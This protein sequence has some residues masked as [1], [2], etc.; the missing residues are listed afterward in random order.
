MKQ[1]RHLLIVFS[2]AVL[3]QLGIGVAQAY[4]NPQTGRW[5]SR[6]PIAEEG[7]PN[8]YA[9][10]NN[11]SICFRDA[12]G[13]QTYDILWN[14]KGENPS[15]AHLYVTPTLTSL[16][17]PCTGGPLS[18]N[19]HFDT[20]QSMD[21]VNWLEDQGAYFTLDGVPNNPTPPQPDP[22]N[23]MEWDNNYM[24]TLPLCPAGDQSGSISLTAGDAKHGTLLNMTFKFKYSCDKCCEAIKPFE[25]TTDYT[26]TPPLYKTTSTKPVPPNAS[27]PQQDLLRL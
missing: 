2:C 27:H 11:N 24:K 1:I 21:G 18:V 14:E 9:F 4:Y 8:L 16:G 23:G 10:V 17:D 7:G 6:D 26:V 3:F 20:G 12:L 19:V 25:F 15:R 13:K 5:L 22:N